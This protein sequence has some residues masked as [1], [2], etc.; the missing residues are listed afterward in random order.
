MT[1]PNPITTYETAHDRKARCAA[2]LLR[3]VELVNA[4][5]RAQRDG[6]DVSTALLYAADDLEFDM[7][8]YNDTCAEF[9]IARGSVCESERFESAN[10]RAPIVD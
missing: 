3:S 1:K 8:A 5:T 10:G 6:T 2:N 9:M 7:D 4:L